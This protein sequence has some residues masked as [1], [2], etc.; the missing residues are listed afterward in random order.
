MNLMTQSLQEKCKRSP[1]IDFTGQLKEDTEGDEERREENAGDIP[2]GSWGLHTEGPSSFAP[3]LLHS[4]RVINCLHRNRSSFTKSAGF[5][6]LR[7]GPP[8]EAEI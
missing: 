5:P 6:F 3:Q 8:G 2:V 1:T 4:I 7:E